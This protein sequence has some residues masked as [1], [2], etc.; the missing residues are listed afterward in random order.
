MTPFSNAATIRIRGLVQGVGFRPHVWH[1]ARA[2]HLIGTVQNDG[3]GVL[4]EVWSA[5]ASALDQ[6]CAALQRD[7]P[8][9][10]QITAIERRRLNHPPPASLTDFHIIASAATAVHTGII[11]DIATCA[12][13][14]AD[15]TD[16]ANRR[17]RY[18]FTNCTHCGPRFSIITALPYDR[19]QT[20][21]AAFPLCPTC[22][23]EYA[24]PADRRFHAQPNACPS[25]GPQL[26]LT[27][28]DGSAVALLDGDVIA[29]TRQLL[30]DGGIVAVQ[31]IGGFHLACDAAHVAAVARLRLRKGRDAKPFALMAA[32]L[33]TIRRYCAVSESEAQL[34]TSPAA[35]IVLLD[36][37]PP[38]Q[39]TGDDLAAAVAPGQ[40][41]LGFMLPYSPLHWLLLTDQPRPLVMTSGNRSAEPQ[42]TEHAD[43]Y[44]Q[45][46]GIADALL[47]HNRGIVNRVD[48]SVA[49]VLLGKTHMLR[50]ARGYA[51]APLYLPDDCVTNTTV[52]A[53][54]AEL[55]STF[56]FV[57][58]NRALLSPHLGDLDNP[59]TFAEYQRMIA[60][61]Q[62]LFALEPAV[63]AV[64]LHPDYRATQYG[65]DWAARAELP[66]IFVQHHHAHLAA[67]LAEHG[68]SRHGGKV[69]G[70]ALD[71]LGYGADGT[72]WG[73]ELL[74]CD[75]CHAERVAH[76]K[77]VALPGGD[78]AA[79][80]PWRNLLA[81]LDAAGV[82]ST[83]VARWSNVPIMQLLLAQPVDLLRQ[84]IAQQ[85]NSPRSSS[86]GRLFDAV[87]A[88]LLPEYAMQLNYDGQ[89][90]QALEMLARPQLAAAGDGYCFEITTDAMEQQVLEPAPIWAELFA[91]LIAGVAPALI[92]ARFHTGLARALV[93]SA[94]QQ[95]ARFGVTTLAL[96]GGVLQN[97]SLLVQITQRAEAAGLR[98]LTAQQVPCHDGGI[99]LGQAVVAGQRY[100]S[101]GKVGAGR[102]M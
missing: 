53:L 12:A 22:A 95:A 63:I 28:P 45:L 93:D 71:G 25:C 39:I 30:R 97:R 64:D 61:Y 68:W 4:I 83:A 51:P 48:D 47:L 14:R 37:L 90:A 38:C 88:A 20:S 29:T 15:L 80:Q 23:A 57:T 44:Q 89:A 91:D 19:V 10:A 79:T 40:D 31:G 21:M 46:G 49:R 16:P 84:M 58:G 32:D 59:R 2:L 50:R 9:L 102:A 24:D 43:A 11:P 8:P 42:V 35:P 96:A 94:Q 62:R 1:C 101:G 87:A 56:C 75:Y 54:G 6:F 85:I 26:T 72:L 36:R 73:A 92:A 41:S 18:A 3:D 27:H 70:W 76:L 52:L 69:L 5:S 66:L 7:C 17:Y 82:W 33:T 81:Q 13:C 34:L 65:R 78:R 98:V 77:A 55:K 99:A 60:A 86:A 100:V 67:V 74:L